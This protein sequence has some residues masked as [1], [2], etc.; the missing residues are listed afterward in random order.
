MNTKLLDSLVQIIHSL[1]EDE[2][3][4]LQ[5]KLLNIAPKKEQKI[6][7]L[8]EILS[9]LEPLAEDFPDIDTGLLPLDDIEL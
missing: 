5:D 9:T 2:Q 1:P 3:Q 4:V 6:S 7:S 8:V